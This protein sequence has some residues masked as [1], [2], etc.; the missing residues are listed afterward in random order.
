MTPASP[1]V[2]K[3]GGELLESAES[4]SAMAQLIAEVAASQAVIVVHGGGR[5]IDAALARAGIPKR[6]VDGLRITDEATLAVVVHVLAGTINT[7]L[8]AAIGA[9]GGPAVGLTGAD[10]AVGLVEPAPPHRSADGHLVSLGLVGR[11]VTANPPRLITG[12]LSE[13]FIP[14][15][16]S[17][18]VDRHGHLF[19]VNADTLAASIAIRTG[20]RR[21]VVAGTTEGV[22]N[23]A[24]QTIPRLDQQTE[25][26]LIAS[27]TVTTGMLAKL[28][29]CRA[30]L[31]AGVTDVSIVDG[32]ST[33]S[34]YAQLTR[35]GSGESPN[36]TQVVS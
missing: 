29:A 13:G 17:I 21:L 11:P 1:I 28:Q 25:R 22:R 8:V 26:T 36:S 15:V 5:E 33:G 12:L 3:C 2:L 14:V 10:A 35:E 27:G 9:A 23:A 34:F 32:R 19:N 20:A 30:A 16:A 24:G 6:Q 7:R 4:V 18:G 31:E